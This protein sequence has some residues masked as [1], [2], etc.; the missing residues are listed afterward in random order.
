MADAAKKAMRLGPFVKVARPEMI[1]AIA[2]A[3]F[4]LAVVDMEHVPVS[5]S[6]LYPLVLAP[7]GAIC[8]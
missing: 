2:L 5:Q 4:D 1:E 8:S 6:D 7:N 3:G